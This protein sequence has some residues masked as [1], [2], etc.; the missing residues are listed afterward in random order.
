[1]RKF[2]ISVRNAVRI[3]THFDKV[4]FDLDTSGNIVEQAEQK[5]D[6]LL[7]TS[8]IEGYSII[9]ISWKVYRFDG[10]KYSFVSRSEN[11]VGD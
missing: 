5:V 11:W 2:V 10:R 4:V 3:I 7:S 6:Q 1:M 9:E 8:G